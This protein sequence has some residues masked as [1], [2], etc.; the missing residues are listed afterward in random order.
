MILKG[1]L[2]DSLCDRSV[3]TKRPPPLATSL[4]PDPTSPP[5]N[6]PRPHIPA[7]KP[8]KPLKTAEMKIGISENTIFMLYHPDAQAL[9]N[10]CSDLEKVCHDLRD[11]NVRIAH[12]VSPPKHVCVCAPVR[13]AL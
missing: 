8:L 3:R 7:L 1:L 9:Y 6:R 2:C 12:Q 4:R 11:P 13:N 5:S 10:V